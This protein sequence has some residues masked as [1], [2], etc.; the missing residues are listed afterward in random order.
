MGWLVDAWKIARVGTTFT[1][2]LLQGAD[3]GSSAWQR[4]RGAF[5]K[6]TVGIDQINLPKIELQHSS[7]EPQAYFKVVSCM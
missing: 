1:T 5:G 6:A 3:A 4:I 7:P 2:E